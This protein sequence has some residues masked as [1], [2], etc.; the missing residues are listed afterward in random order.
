MYGS[1]NV[2][3]L[4]VLEF[5]LRRACAGANFQEI[6]LRKVQFVLHET[7]AAA[8]IP[9]RLPQSPLGQNSE[10]RGVPV[11]GR[12]HPFAAGFGIPPPTAP[13]RLT[14]IPIHSSR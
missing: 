10:S 4:P 7:S 8:E 6:S 12:I 9:Q 1:P 14:P 2:P 11:R 3:L 5:P 13:V